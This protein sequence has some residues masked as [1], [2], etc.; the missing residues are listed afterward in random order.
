MW[1]GRSR[2]L[3]CEPIYSQTTSEPDTTTTKSVRRQ[4]KRIA[5]LARQKKI[6]RMHFQSLCQQGLRAENRKGLGKTDHARGTCREPP[7]THA[8]HLTRKLPADCNPGTLL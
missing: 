1:S 4:S 7:Q 5:R 3:C 6:A 8:C 2:L